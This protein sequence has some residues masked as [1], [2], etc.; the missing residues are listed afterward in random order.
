MD[1]FDESQEAATIIDASCLWWT[2]RVD[3]TGGA[4]DLLM[5]KPVAWGRDALCQQRSRPVRQS[6]RLALA[7]STKD[8]MALAIDA[9]VNVAPFQIVMLAELPRNEMIDA[10]PRLC[11]CTTLADRLRLELDR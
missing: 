6:T 1:D 4:R 3:H 10:S 2:A 5:H 7:S 9:V 8:V 11:L